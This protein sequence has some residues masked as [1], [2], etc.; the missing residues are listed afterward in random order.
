MYILNDVGDEVQSF[1]L[2]VP[3]GEE[4]LTFTLDEEESGAMFGYD[5]KDPLGPSG[6]LG[7]LGPLGPLGLLGPLGA[8]GPDP[9]LDGLNMMGPSGLLGSQ[10]PL[11]PSGPL[12]TLNSDVTKFSEA[13]TNYYT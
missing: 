8:L 12:G 1:E 2:E 5:K 3:N 6:P 4:L 10:G 11:G 9:K 7:A 13:S